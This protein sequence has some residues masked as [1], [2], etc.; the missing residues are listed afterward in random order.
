LNFCLSSEE[1]TRSVLTHL[2]NELEV[3]AEAK[4]SNAEAFTKL[5][6]QYDRNIYRLAMNIT[7]NQEDAEDVLQE[8]FLKAYANLD[9]FQG[10][11]RFYTWLVRIAVN[12]AL[13][14]LRKRRSDRS[15]SLDEPITTDDNQ[16][17]PREIADWGDN[18][19]ESCAKAE[20]QEVLSRGIETLQPRY[21]VVVLLRDVEHLSA[22]EAAALLGL[23][24][25]AVKTRLYR[26]HLKL[27]ERLSEILER[28]TE[29]RCPATRNHRPALAGWRTYRDLE[30]AHPV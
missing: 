27:R 24:L 11:S 29:S 26:A 10:N 6:N 3:V 21:R 28:P 12:E 1:G 4:A 5:V 15:V 16:V 8:A 30:G 17:I 19:E 22:G 9:R 7:G 25:P 20:L 2:D 18:P 23:T 13:M 14:K